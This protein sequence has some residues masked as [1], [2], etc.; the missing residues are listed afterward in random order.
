MLTN[1]WSDIGQ[2]DQFP[3]ERQ[4]SDQL[5]IFVV[6]VERND[7]YAIFWLYSIR[8]ARIV[9]NNHILMVAIDVA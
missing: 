6:I 7:R 2:C 5:S 9:D 4:Q 8:Y 1:S 3:K